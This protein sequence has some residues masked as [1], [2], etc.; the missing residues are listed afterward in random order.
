[1]ESL[2]AMSCGPEDIITPFCS[3][4]REIPELSSV[5]SG[6]H[7][8]P[9][10][11]AS[12]HIIGGFLTGGGRLHFRRHDSAARVKKLMPDELW[13]RYTK[14]VVMRNPF[15]RIVSWYFWDRKEGAKS[16]RTFKDYVLRHQKRITSFRDQTQ[17]NG[18]EIAD[19]YLRFEDLD[20]DIRTL[21]MRL[22]I[23]GLDE[24]L[25]SS[26]R[27]KSG[28][29]PAYAQPETMFADFPE[30][31]ELISNLCA[32]EISRFNYSLRAV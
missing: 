8:V 5:K 26:L 23:G 1:M 4:Q 15:D 31:V 19:V 16:G 21:Y 22:G 17:V 11:W 9:F 13:N 29:R 6:T 20:N 24:S 7:R 32:D 27:L 18:K 25:L 2:L 30:G 10:V 12:G 3:H 14:V 28:H